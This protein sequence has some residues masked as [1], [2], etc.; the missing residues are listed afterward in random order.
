M[1]LA[2]ETTVEDV[3][4]VIENMGLVANEDVELDVDA[5]HSRLNFDKIEKAVLYYDDMDEQ[6]EAANQEIEKQLRK[7]FAKKNLISS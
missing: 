7:M 5:L 2:W 4:T 6:I 1:S 3:D